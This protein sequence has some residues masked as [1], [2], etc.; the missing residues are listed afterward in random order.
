M[1]DKSCAIQAIH[2]KKYIAPFRLSK[3]VQARRT[4]PWPSLFCHHH[5]DELLIIDLAIAVDVCLSDH[6]INFLIRKL[7]AKVRHDVA[8]L[9]CTDEAVTI[10][11]EN[12]ERLNQLF[13]SIRI[14]HLTCHKR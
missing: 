9:S 3:R 1:A 13:F 14:F 10:A 12:L 6:F 7:L 11:I 8:K 5:L 4:L 2:D